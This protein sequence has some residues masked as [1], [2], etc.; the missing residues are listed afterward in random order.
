MEECLKKF[1]TIISNEFVTN[2]ESVVL[3]RQLVSTP[4]A[5][6]AIA[7]KLN[8]PISTFRSNISPFE[9]YIENVFSNLLFKTLINGIIFFSFPEENIGE[10]ADLKMNIVNYCKTRMDIYRVK[11]VFISFFTIYTIYMNTTIVK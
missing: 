5:V 6:D 8:L 7:S 10:N 1:D 11:L 2:S 3:P 9:E 4:N